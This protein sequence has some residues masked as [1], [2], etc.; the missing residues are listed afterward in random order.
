MPFLTLPS[1]F[2]SSAELRVDTNRNREKIRQ[3]IDL[4]EQ[5]QIL[6]QE[7]E[8]MEE[9]RTNAVESEEAASIVS[10]AGVAFMVL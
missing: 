7:L 4:L 3:S 8:K 1:H 10:N 9:A 2:L 6:V 5:R